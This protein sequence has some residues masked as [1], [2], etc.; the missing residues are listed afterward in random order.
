MTKTREQELADRWIK[1][2]RAALVEAEQGRAENR[3][4]AE[5]LF[6]T[7]GT[8]RCVFTRYGSEPSIKTAAIEAV[9]FV[10]LG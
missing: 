1:D 6:K 9:V 4:R 2:Y 10:Y 7:A 8:L 5:R 3:A